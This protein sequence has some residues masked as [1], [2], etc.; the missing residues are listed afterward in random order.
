MEISEEE[1]IQV[2][3]EDVAELK[4][5]QVNTTQA[6]RSMEKEFANIKG[7]MVKC[8]VSVYLFVLFVHFSSHCLRFCFLYRR[9]SIRDSNNSKAL[10]RCGLIQNVVSSESI[11]VSHCR[12]RL[13]D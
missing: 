13:S 6:V 10:T 7:N 9:K 3:E 11:M 12:C 5:L 1:A 4:E 2:Y 8:V